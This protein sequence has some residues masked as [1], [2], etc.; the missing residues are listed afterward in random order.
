MCSRGVYQLAK[1]SLYF[2][3][4]GGSSAGVRSLLLSPKIKEF[5]SNNPQL[6]IDFICKRNN[7][8]YISGSY[9]NGYNK[10][11]PLRSMSPEDVLDKLTGLRDQLG[12]TSFKAS[13]TRVFGAVKSLQGKWQSNIFNR[14]P[15]A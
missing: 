10:S 1:L 4:Y 7:H 15:I 6:K 3:D 2:C 14:Y 13:G 5:I 12:R 8:P 9:I 11:V